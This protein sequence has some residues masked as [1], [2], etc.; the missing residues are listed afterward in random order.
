MNQLCIIWGYQEELSSTAGHGGSA[1]ARSVG[2]TSSP[3]A[4]AVLRL[5]H[6]LKPGRLL[7]RQVGRLLALENPAGVEARRTSSLP[8]AFME[9]TPPSRF[10]Q[11]L[12]TRTG[13][14]WTRSAAPIRPLPSRRVLR[15]PHS[16]GGQACRSSDRASNPIRAGDYCNRNTAKALDIE[17]PPTLLALADE[18]AALVICGP[19][20]GTQIANAPSAISINPPI[21]FQRRRRCSRCGILIAG[22]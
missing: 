3:S 14:L 8:S 18:D 1:R 12:K 21:I 6:E 9:T 22:C 16:Q 11:K 13:R 10:S 20:A 19:T 15:G 7:D 17:I 4:V 5:I 2:G